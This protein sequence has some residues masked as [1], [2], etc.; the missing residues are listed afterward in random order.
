MRKKAVETCEMC[1]TEVYRP[2]T[3]KVEGALLNVCQNCTSFG[4][5]VEKPKSRFPSS[6][7]STVSPV[8][9]SRGGLRSSPRPKFRS[10]QDTSDKELVTD[11]ANVIR[12]A[13][14]KQKITQEQL[15][16]MTGLSIPFIKSMEAGKTRPTDAA[17]KTLERELK[18]ELL[19]TP[20]VEL[21]YSEKTKG[22]A[23]TLGDIAVIKRFEYDDD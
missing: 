16:T 1:S 10:K 23:T 8:K 9:S 22:K 19:Y 18:I 20:E 6:S 3:I 17:A 14:M 12:S 5:I 7:Q 15:A 4:N 2:V 13:R 21:E 11:F